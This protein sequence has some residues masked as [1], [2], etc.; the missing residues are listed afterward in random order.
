MIPK[1]FLSLTI[2]FALLIIGTAVFSQTSSTSSVK[3]LDLNTATL[4]ELIALRGIG[5]KY[6][7][8][9]I[10]GRPYKMKTE[11]VTKRILTSKAYRRI[12]KKV[13]AKQN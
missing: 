13:I 9:I 1:Q 12:S 5:D 4:E 2:T 7:A 8:R 10:E 11:L 6:A 3:L